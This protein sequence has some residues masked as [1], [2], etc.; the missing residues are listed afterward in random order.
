MTVPSQKILVPLNATQTETALSLIRDDVLHGV[1][2]K[3]G[4][5]LFWKLNTGVDDIT[6]TI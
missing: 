6:Y 1:Y 5:R 4:Y 3:K 2:L